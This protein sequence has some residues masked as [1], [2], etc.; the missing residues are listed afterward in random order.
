MPRFRQ[1]WVYLSCKG[2]V[3]RES[4]ISPIG[5]PA[6]GGKNVNGGWRRGMMVIADLFGSGRRR[7]DQGRD[8][9]TVE[10]GD[11]GLSSLLRLP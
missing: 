6:M 1:D 9:K 3:M 8:M 11:P 7:Q 5:T 10:R 4:V 2:G